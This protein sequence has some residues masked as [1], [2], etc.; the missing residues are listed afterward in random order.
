M[1]N[2]KLFLPT[3]ILVAAILLTTICALVG[4][5]VF[6]PEITEGE[7]PFS[8]TYEVDG[9]TVTVNEVYKVRYKADEG[10]RSRLYVGE[11]G[12]RGEDNT[13]YIL[14]KD[15]IGRIELCTHFYPDYLMGDPEYDYFD[16]EPFEPR[17]YYYD[18]KENEHYDEETLSKLGVKLISFEYPEP[19]ENSLAFSHMVMPESEVIFPAMAIAFLAMIATL[20]FVKKDADYV[21]KPIN[22]VTIVFNFV[23]AFTAFPFYT[24][25]AGMLSALGDMGNVMNLV[26]Y[27]LPALTILCITA[28]IG[29]R[30]KL[31]GK[32]ALVVQFVSPAVFAVMM[33]ISEVYELL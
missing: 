27:L 18:A 16:D 14:K 5:I 19:I 28:S 7:F 22:V 30:R 11:I 1:K 25:I 12:S 31:Y 17:I 9:E 10:Y 23:I 24:I 26:I 29:L 21:R 2:K 32:S 3:V 15:E 33:L 4:G 13:T 6:K 20:I 8:I